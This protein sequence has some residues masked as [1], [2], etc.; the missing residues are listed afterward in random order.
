MSRRH[1]RAHRGPRLHGFRDSTGSFKPG[2]SFAPGHRTAGATSV[3]APTLSPTVGTSPGSRSYSRTGR[4]STC[5]R[6]PIA[7]IPCP[8]FVAIFLR[9]VTRTLP[10]G[11]LESPLILDPAN[12]HGRSLSSSAH[13]ARA[14]RAHVA[15]FSS[16]RPFIVLVCCGKSPARVSQA[17]VR[18]SDTASLVVT[19]SL[20]VASWACVRPCDR[21]SDNLSRPDPFEPARVP[22]ES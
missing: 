10:M 9:N 16:Q 14:T 7:S 12:L 21:I 18:L 22:H 11:T 4:P 20:A 17:T 6:P 8:S 2:G 15:H 1:L 3:S 5:S 19:C 13:Y